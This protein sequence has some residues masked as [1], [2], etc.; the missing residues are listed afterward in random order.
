VLARL[1]ATYPCQLKFVIAAPGDLAEVEAL[2]ARL[3]AVDPE[4]V[5]L[6]PLGTRPEELAPRGRWLAE[7]CKERGYRFTPRLH[8]DLFGNRRGT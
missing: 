5:L 6:M 2:L 7:I 3:P 4:A 8:I 1:L